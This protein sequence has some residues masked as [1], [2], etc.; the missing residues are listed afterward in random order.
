MKLIEHAV[1]MGRLKSLNMSMSQGTG[2]METTMDFQWI[3]T[4]DGHNKIHQ[5]MKTPQ[6]YY[7]F[8]SDQLESLERVMLESII[9]KVIVE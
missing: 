1:A 2:R 6:T 7:L 8:S 4:K 5:N 3:L 9:N